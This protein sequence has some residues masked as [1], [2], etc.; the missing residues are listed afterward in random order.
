M[1]WAI[2]FLRTMTPRLLVPLVAT[3]C[4][5]QALAQQVEITPQG[6]D[7]DEWIDPYHPLTIALDK[8]AR[9]QQARLAFFIGSN[10]VTGAMQ[11]VAPGIYQY[12]ASIS[13]LPSGE[14][15]LKVYLVRPQNQ[16]DEL[17]TLTLRVLT[18][19]GFE[20]Q[21][22]VPQLTLSDAWQR[23]TTSS[24]NEP[25]EDSTQTSNELTL[26]GGLNTRHQ[27]SAVEIRSSWNISGS[28][29]VEQALRFAEKGDE[30]PRIDLSDYLIEVESTST[31]IQLGHVSYGT[32]PL[33]MDNVANRGITTSWRAGERV[34]LSFSAQ[35]GQ[36]I[37]GASNLTG[38]TD[39]DRNRI[40]GFG[41]GVD[42]L[43]ESA[44]QFRLELTML[45]AKIIAADS[46]NSGEVSDAQKS[47]GLGLQLRGSNASGRL[48]GEFALARSTFSNP[49]DPFLEQDFEVV[50]SQQTT[51]LSRSLQLD[52]DV[53]PATYDEEG[54]SG[55]SMTA[56]IKHD[57]TD[58]F[59]QSA[60][61]FI[62]PD[63][64]QNSLSLQGQAGTASW[65]LQYS[66]SR[67]NLDNIATVLT[68][69]NRNTVAALSIPLSVEQAWLPQSITLDMQKNHQFGDSLPVSFDPDSHIPDQVTL[70]Q[71]LA[72]E[73][74]IDQTSLT[75]QYSNSDQDNRQPGRD[76]ADFINTE[77][78][79]SVNT[80]LT[81]SVNL[82]LSFSRSE[83]D[84]Q[85][86][87]VVRTSDSI[88]SSVDWTLSEQLA[89]SINLSDSQEDDS[90]NLGESTA[91]SIQA[92]LSYNFELPGGAAGK[93]PV[94]FFI[95]YAQDQNSSVDRQ[96][97]LTTDSE[98]K[99]FNAGLN[100]S[101]F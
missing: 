44:A 87:N 39:F 68:T 84:D 21:E 46:F 48:R 85:E 72:L 42:L 90:Q 34:D 76:N 25:P 7:P 28:S 61:A 52:Y 97:D 15:A 9:P 45:D 24:N 38:L 59:Y 22:I 36:A 77:H 58:P 1:I 63:M 14:H 12:R 93:L 100:V 29:D 2:K 79:L 51:D 57:R 55:W 37:T 69:I 40:A 81:E 30:A 53:L 78:A 101:F 64:Q 74:L 66:Q 99:A 16:W 73:W 23:N 11:M 3:M 18:E 54:N 41:V 95:R 27:R 56:S 47:R 91:Q 83:A 60:G 49:A 26:Q 89:L 5:A 94:Q 31:L 17:A 32:N 43:P 4:S 8:V 10:D 88:S 92:Q 71:S 82:T 98:N 19:S 70:Q 20:S 13:P 6:F 67:D 33:L 62:T 35:N 50:A 80:V 96:F 65:Q 75:Y 86:Q